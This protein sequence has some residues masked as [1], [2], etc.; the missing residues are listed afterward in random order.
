ME[1]NLLQMTGVDA[2]LPPNS[3]RTL[4]A[5]R[6]LM[7]PHRRG[8]G[9]SIFR[10]LGSARW[11]SRKHRNLAGSVPFPRAKNATRFRKQSERGILIS[12][13]EEDG[14]FS[15]ALLLFLFDDCLRKNLGSRCFRVAEARH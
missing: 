15:Y 10:D 14:P 4:R 9:K 2:Q 5:N 1:V 3:R 11:S 8:C 6:D 12:H 7:R 13:D